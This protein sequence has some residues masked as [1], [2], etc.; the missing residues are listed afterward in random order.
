MIEYNIQNNIGNSKYVVN[1]YT[2][3]KHKDGSKFYDIA[4]FKNK[5]EWESFTK[6]RPNKY[7][8]NKRELI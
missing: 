5:K 1:Y 2:G 3:K 8:E 6:R 7:F 4:I